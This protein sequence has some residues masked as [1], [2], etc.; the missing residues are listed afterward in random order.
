MTSFIYNAQ[1]EREKKMSSDPL[2]FFAAGDDSSDSEEEE[3]AGD[4]RTD[5]PSEAVNDGADKLPSPNSLFKSV[6]RPS[7]LNNPNEKFIDWDKFVKKNTEVEEPSVHEREGYVAIPPPDSL[8]EKS[9]PVTSSLTRTILGTGTV[10][11]SSPPVRY[12]NGP[13][14]SGTGTSAVTSVRETLGDTQRQVKRAQ[15]G[16][17]ESETSESPA[18]KKAKGALFR[19]KEKRKRDIGQSSRGKNYVEEEKRILRQQFGSD[20]ILS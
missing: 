7:F 15:E 2:N 1:L 4:S 9:G 3:D 5:K 14:S 16:A 6:G 18:A 19:V 11:F 10:E 20:P 12:D 13:V 17:S 8:K